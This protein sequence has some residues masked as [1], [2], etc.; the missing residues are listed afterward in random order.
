MLRCLRYL[1]IFQ[2]KNPKIILPIYFN[3][4]EIID[5]VALAQ[6]A[7]VLQLEEYVVTIFLLVG[8]LFYDLV[9]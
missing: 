3:G 4:S 8:Q 2:G 9:N 5:I 7:S 6:N 1:Q